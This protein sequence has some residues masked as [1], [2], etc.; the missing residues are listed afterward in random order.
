M[1]ATLTHKHSTYQTLKIE[2]HGSAREKVASSFKTGSPKSG[3]ERLFAL[4]IQ[5]IG[6]DHL[7][8]CKVLFKNL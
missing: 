4:H 7:E 6:K 2:Q 8:R 5:A 3:N 1:D